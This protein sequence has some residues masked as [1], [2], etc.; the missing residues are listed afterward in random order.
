MKHVHAYLSSE[1]KDSGR[2]T[3]IIDSGASSHMV[4]HHSWFWTY[5]PLDPP[6][7]VT[8]GD[9][10]DAMAI[11]VRTVPLISHV[12]GTT[13][14]I[15]LSNVLL[16]PEF[17][18]SLISVNCLS[19]AGLSTTFPAG[20]KKC[21]IQKD[22]NTTLFTIQKNGLYHARVTPNNQKEAI[23]ATVDINLLH[24]CMGHVSPNWI[25]QMVK[26]GQ[27]P[28]IDTLSGTPT[29]CEA[30]TLGK[31]KKLPFELQD[32]PHTTRPL[33]MVHMDVGGPITPKSRE[34]YRY[35]IVIVD[36][37]THFPW[38]YFMKHKSEALGIYNQ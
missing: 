10:S 6:H 13:Y 9:N 34:G 25:Q 5:Q 38:V 12:S 33:E 18:I 30:C 11:G 27:L 2:N 21:Y 7:P 20:S 35:W 14:E 26:S 22:Q 23:H 8:L 1:P 17:Q 3:L 16:I 37:F 36:N 31:M 32:G 28:G 29:F 4:P 15:I 19:S 24:W